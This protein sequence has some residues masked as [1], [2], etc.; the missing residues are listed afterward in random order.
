MWGVF[1]FHRDL[2]LYQ[3]SY[4][5]EGLT[6]LE[7]AT[8]TFTRVTDKIPAHIAIQFLGWAC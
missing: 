8:R 5:P 4:R 2:L 6:G 7:P 3:L 1:V